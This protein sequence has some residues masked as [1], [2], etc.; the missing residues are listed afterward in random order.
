MKSLQHVLHLPQGLQ[1]DDPDQ[2]PKPL[3]L[4]P[5]S[6]EEQRLYSEPLPDVRAPHPISEAEPSHPAKKAHFGYLYWQSHCFA[7][8]P[9][10]MT[11]GESWKV[12]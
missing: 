10:L 4:A 7:H 5:L 3:K 8:Y 2:M 11:I 6:A 12:D 9:E 1:G